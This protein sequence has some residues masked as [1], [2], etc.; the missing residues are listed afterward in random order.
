[1]EIGVVQIDIH[2][3]EYQFHRISFS[4]INCIKTLIKN[5][6]RIDSYMQNEHNWNLFE[7]GNVKPLNQELLITYI[8]LDKLIE[9]AKLNIKQ[10]YIVER[11]FEGYEE[12]DIAEMFKQDVSPIR[13]TLDVICNKI[14]I[15]NDQEWKYNYM[16][17]NYLK[18]KWSYKTC[19]RCGE[20]KP[21]L[22]EFFSLD[23]SKKDG[24]KGVCKQCKK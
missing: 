22:R 12:R 17:M 15:I 6:W 1:M 19:S 4:D 14:K 8:D 13:R 18:A 3:S 24:F 5:R 16:Y 2:K 21:R 7:S 11:L 9:K 20:S 10:K 23:S